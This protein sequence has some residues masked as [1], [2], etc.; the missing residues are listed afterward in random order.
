M[1]TVKVCIQIY[2]PRSLKQKNSKPKKLNK[3]KYRKQNK[4]NKLKIS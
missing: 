4:K 2:N 3:K 1:A